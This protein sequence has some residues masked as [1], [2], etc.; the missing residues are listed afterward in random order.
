MRK[1]GECENFINLARLS[2][3]F[4]RTRTSLLLLVLLSTILNAT[5]SSF[6]YWVDSFWSQNFIW[7]WAL[8]PHDEAK[9]VSLQ[10]LH[11]NVC[12]SI[13]NDDD[14]FVWIASNLGDFSVKNRLGWNQK[15][16]KIHP[17]Y[18]P[19]TWLALLDKNQFEGK[20]CAYEYNPPRS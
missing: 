19:V 4:F 7:K 2:S 15:N 5:I 3:R 17:T 18:S 9:L 20:A 6:E 14:S 1:S 12:L 16:L 13:D 11:N 8:K 10:S